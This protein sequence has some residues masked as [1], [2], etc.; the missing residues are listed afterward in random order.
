[1]T[2]T[3]TPTIDLETARMAADTLGLDLD[4]EGFDLE[5]LRRGMNVELEHGRRSPETNVTN[6]DPIVTA[7]IALAHLREMPDYYEQLATIEP[8]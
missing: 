3:P 5:T 7:K 4:R 8:D 2:E 1:M 6:D